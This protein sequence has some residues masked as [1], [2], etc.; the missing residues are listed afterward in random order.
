MVSARHVVAMPIARGGSHFITFFSPCLKIFCSP[1]DRTFLAQ[2]SGGDIHR[3]TEVMG[4]VQAHISAAPLR[5]VKE[6]HAAFYSPEDQYASHG[7]HMEQGLTAARLRDIVA[8]HRLYIILISIDYAT[9]SLYW[10]LPY[11]AV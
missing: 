5:A 4:Q 1:I 3:L 7:M 6:W 2:R 8:N 11:R 10:K 9:C